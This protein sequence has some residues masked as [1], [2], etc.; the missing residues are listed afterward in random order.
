MENYYFSSP[1]TMI[2][3]YNPYGVNFLRSR[4]LPLADLSRLIEEA[5]ERGA[6][7]GPAGRAK[8]SLR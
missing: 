5:A 7:Q 3:C 8:L 4:F 6:E 1:T 2:S